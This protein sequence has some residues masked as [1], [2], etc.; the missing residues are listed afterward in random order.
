M[1]ENIRP[2]MNRIRTMIKRILTVLLS[3]GLLLCVTASVGR[4][5][6]RLFYSEVLLSTLNPAISSAVD[7][8][9]SSPRLYGLYDAKIL[10]IKRLQPGGFAFK[11]TVQVTTFVG[12]HNPPYGVE[13]MT[14]AIDAGSAKVIQYQH[15]DEETSIGTNSIP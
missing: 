3:S 6:D 5:V 12:A 15:E 9:Y 1:V 13:T 14:I 11:V 2:T 10:D 8:Y 4:K 7:A